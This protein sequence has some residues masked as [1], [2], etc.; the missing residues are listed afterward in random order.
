MLLLPLLL[1]LLPLLLLRLL[2]LLLLLLSTYP[3]QG[4]RYVAQAHSVQR[5]QKMRGEP[6]RRQN[7]FLH[8]EYYA[9]NTSLGRCNLTNYNF[10]DFKIPVRHR[11]GPAR[12]SNSLPAKLRAAQLG[13]EPEK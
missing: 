8:L 1:L 3:V 12:T 11:D 9:Y 13:A 7:E 6:E 4:T 2:L 10:H 5:R